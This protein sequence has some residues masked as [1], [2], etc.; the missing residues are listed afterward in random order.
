MI[1]SLKKLVH[2]VFVR[3]VAK[4]GD[5][6]EGKGGGCHQLFDFFKLL[7][8]DRFLQRFSR[9]VDKYSA[10]MSLAYVEFL[11]NIRGTYAY[12]VVVGDE[13][14]NLLD[15]CF[16]FAE[17]VDFRCFSCAVWMSS[18]HEFQHQTFQ[19][20]CDQPPPDC[21]VVI[22]LFDGD[23]KNIP[24]MLRFVIRDQP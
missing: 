15:S 20:A 6:L 11:R 5:F 4:L 22:I 12:S 16:V 18:F 13:S 23:V 19:I 21:R 10:K 1:V 7:A 2:A 14:L 17:S 24:H 9:D 3:K 8:I